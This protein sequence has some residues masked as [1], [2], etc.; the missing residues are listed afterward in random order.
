M[1]ILIDSDCYRDVQRVGW[2]HS[3]VRGVQ[4]IKDAYTFMLRNVWLYFQNTV[5]QRVLSHWQLL[6]WSYTINSVCLLAVPIVCEY[7]MVNLLWCSVIS[8]SE[9]LQFIGNYIYSSSPE[10]CSTFLPPMFD[11]SS[12]FNIHG[13]TFIDASGG[14]CSGAKHYNYFQIIV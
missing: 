13:G 11:K 5:V 7:S 9:I 8:V 4:N 2:I 6:Q 3:R 12:N 14:S 1:G 10:L